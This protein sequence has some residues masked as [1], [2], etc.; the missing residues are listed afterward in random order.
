VANLVGNAL[1]HGGAP[2]RL[3]LRPLP[4][5]GGAEIEVSDRGPGIPGAALPHL[6]DRFFKAGAART[7]SESSGLGLAIT[8]ENVRL[9]GG[10]VTAANRPDGGAVFT[11]RLP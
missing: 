10:T 6:F 11:V 2:V 9:H 7:R 1:K 8:H 5:P 4:G 3:A